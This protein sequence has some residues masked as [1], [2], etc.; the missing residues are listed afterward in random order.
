MMYCR[1]GNAHRDRNGGQCPPYLT[2][3]NKPGLIQLACNGCVYDIGEAAS[4]SSKVTSSQA[5]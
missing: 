5:D 3:T 4:S 2:E 1:V